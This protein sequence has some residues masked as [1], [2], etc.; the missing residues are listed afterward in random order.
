AVV[1]FFE[2]PGQ[3]LVGHQMEE[4][5]FHGERDLV[6]GARLERVDWKGFYTLFC[7]NRYLAHRRVQCCGLCGPARGVVGGLVAAVR[8]LEGWIN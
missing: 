6:A 1:L 4:A 5:H 2:V 7:P 8:A 3:I